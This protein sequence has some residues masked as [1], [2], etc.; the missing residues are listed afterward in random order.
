MASEG[1]KGLRFHYNGIL[2]NKREGDMASRSRSRSPPSPSRR[3]DPK[4]LGWLLESQ[5]EDA[6]HRPCR[7]DKCCFERWPVFIALCVV[8]AAVGLLYSFVHAKGVH[9]NEHMKR[10]ED[11]IYIADEAVAQLQVRVDSII[12]SLTGVGAAAMALTAEGAHHLDIKVFKHLAWNYQF[13]AG[14]VSTGLSFNAH[15]LHS[16]RAAFEAQHLADHNPA[17]LN[18]SIIEFGQYGLQASPAASE[19]SVVTYIEPLVYE[20]QAL[21]YNIWSVESRR[22]A[23]NASRRTGL[24]HATTFVGMCMCM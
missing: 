11:F 20:Q 3:T 18:F 7:L 10:I 19:Y 2:E 16:E 1:V 23:I 21:G 14:S 9:D 15:V 13:S 4:E 5:E 17:D 22:N 8:V 6:E 24:P 12:G